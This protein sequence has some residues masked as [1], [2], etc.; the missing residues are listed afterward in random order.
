MKYKISLFLLIGIVLY[1]IDVSLNS[2][3]DKE[4][5]ISDQEI[6]SLV[7][8][9]KSQVG[10]NPND[11]EITRI[12]N[13][14]VDEE[15]LYREALALGLEKNDRIIKRR[16][17]QK[18]SFL[19]EESILDSP[20]KDDLLNYFE[21]NKDKLNTG[22][23]VIAAITSCTNTSNP[24]VMIAAGL[25]AKKAIDLG[26]EVKPWVKTSL[27]PGSKVVSD[28]L[29]KAG[30]TEY[31]DLLGFN[32]VGYGCTTCIG[33]S[34][35]LDEW[36]SNEIKKN[37]LTVCSVLSGNRNFEG[38]VHQEVKANFLASPPLVVAYAIAGNINVNLTTDSIGKSK[39]GKKI[40]LKDL[41]PSNKEIN[42]TLSLCLT[43]EMFKE[44]YKEIYKGDDNWKSINN[45]KDTTYDWNDTSTYIKHPPFFDTKNEF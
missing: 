15:I 24:N 25:V 19:K 14:L 37:N 36:V 21:N 39:S 38:R 8:A 1:F 42:Q 33:N 5:F 7:N 18:I 16:L 9:W 10:R 4:I 31:L 11:D 41:W 2:Y 35:P 12:I 3:D 20:T 22:D 40:Y 44:R 23:I 30:L 26:L 32:T 27:A 43:P 29:D 45:S 28:Y 34:G 13:N 6:L 17:A